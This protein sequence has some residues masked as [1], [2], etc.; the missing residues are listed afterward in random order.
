MSRIYTPSVGCPQPSSTGSGAESR[1]WSRLCG[2]PSEAGQGQTI[3]FQ[4]HHSTADGW[5]LL[6]AWDSSHGQLSPQ[7]GAKRCRAGWDPP[8]C[9]PSFGLLLGLEISIS[10]GCCAQGH[11]L[12][13][14][15]CAVAGAGDGGP[16][17][18]FTVY[19]KANF[20][21]GLCITRRNFSS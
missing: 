3:P 7:W 2:P 19:F 6:R 16:R 13:L 12:D 9:P 17:N 8:L 18:C 4:S 10:S 20:T 11:S 15:G 5:V 21:Q 1:V 14:P